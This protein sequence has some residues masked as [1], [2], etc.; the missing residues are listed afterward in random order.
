LSLRRR[1]GL[2]DQQQNALHRDER[3]EGAQYIVDQQPDY[4]APFTGDQSNVPA[5]PSDIENADG[6]TSHDSVKVHNPL[7]PDRPAYVTESTGRLLYLGHSSTYAFTQQLLHLTGDS[8]LSNPSPEVNLRSN[9]PAHKANSCDLTNVQDPDISG[10]PSKSTALYH[11]QSVKFRTQPLY[12]LYDELEFLEALSAFYSMPS[13][14]ARSHPIWFANYLII[15]AFGI[16]LTSQEYEGSTSRPS[17]RD[18]FTRALALAPDMSYLC[19]YPIQ[20]TELYC[21]I[22]LYY[23]SIHDRCPALVYVGGLSR[24]HEDD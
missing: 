16:A 24:R 2:L 8:P 9:G 11:L 13:E 15:M 22:A 18:F 3:E 20:A 5:T 17:S 7:A 6:A 12:F 14:Y 21:S 10:L 23:Q 4:V 1:A 19:E